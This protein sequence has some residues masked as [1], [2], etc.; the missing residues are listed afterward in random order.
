[1][2]GQEEDVVYTS[3]GRRIQIFQDRTVYL[4]TDLTENFQHAV[5]RYRNPR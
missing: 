1:M 5:K 3:D 2:K 4:R